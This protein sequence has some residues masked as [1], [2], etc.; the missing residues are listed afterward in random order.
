M[1][2]LVRLVGVRQL[3]APTPSPGAELDALTRSIREHG[4]LYPLLIREKDGRYEIV[5]GKRRYAA[6]VAAGLTEV[7]CIVKQLDDKEAEALALAKTRAEAARPV[8]FAPP[9]R[10]SSRRQ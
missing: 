1:D 3:Q 9:L 6:A 4:I 5:A 7:P 2:D 8:R 10:R